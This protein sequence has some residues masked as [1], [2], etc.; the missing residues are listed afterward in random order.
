MNSTNDI[1]IYGFKPYLRYSENITESIIEEI[2][3]RE[4]GR[5]LVFDVEFNRRMFTDALRRYSPK[6]ILGLG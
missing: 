3:N 5:G 1:L 6:I 4:I 2:N